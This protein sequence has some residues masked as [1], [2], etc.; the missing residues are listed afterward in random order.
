[1]TEVYAELLTALGELGEGE[2]LSPREAVPGGQQGDH[3]LLEQVVSAER[4][5]FPPGCSGVLESER[6]MQATI[7]NARLEIAHATFLNADLQVRPASDE[8][9]DRGRDDRGQ[10]AR[11]GRDHSPA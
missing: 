11:G 5:R 7:A 6:D 3:G 10:G 8:P 9:G 2:R 4:V 1:M